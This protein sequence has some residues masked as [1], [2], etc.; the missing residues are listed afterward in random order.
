MAKTVRVD[1]YGRVTTKLWTCEGCEMVIIDGYQIEDDVTLCRP[2]AEENIREAM[3]YISYTEWKEGDKGC[4][5]C[6]I[7]QCDECHDKG[8]N[9]R[10]EHCVTCDVCSVDTT[11]DRTAAG[12]IAWHEDAWKETGDEDIYKQTMRELLAV[13]L[14]KAGKYRAA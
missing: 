11:R 7:E 8:V 9:V 4:E 1:K 5:H 3:D 6:R 14:K 2:C 12:W 13:E 10:C